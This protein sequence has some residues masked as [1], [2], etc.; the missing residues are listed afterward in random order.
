MKQRRLTCGRW[1]GLTGVCVEQRWQVAGEVG[2]V[3]LGSVAS[4]QIRPNKIKGRGG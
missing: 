3:A 4:Q 1:W 2:F